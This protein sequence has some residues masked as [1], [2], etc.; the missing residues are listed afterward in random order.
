MRRIVFGI[1]GLALTVLS[2][3]VSALVLVIAFVLTV[4]AP[5]LVV[6]FDF[7]AVRK[8]FRSVIERDPAARGAVEIILCY[9]GFHAVL[10]HRFVHFLHAHMHVPVVPRAMSQIVRWFTG[11]EIHPGAALGRGVFIDHGMGVVIGETAIVGDDVTLFQGVTLGGTG[12]ETGKRHPTLE[13]GVV[14]GAGA[15]ILGNIRIGRNARVGGGSVVVSEVPPE[16]TVVGVPG[17]IVVHK[18]RKVSG[19]SLDHGNLPDPVREALQNLTN[20][21]RDTELELHKEQDFLHDIASCKRREVHASSAEAPLEEVKA[22]AASPPTERISFL[23][24]IRQEGI[25][26]IGEIKRASPSRGIIRQDFDVPGLAEALKNGG[27]RALSVLTDRCYFHGALE[28]IAAAKKASGLPVLRKDFLIDPYQ[29]WQAKAAGADAVLL[30]AR[31]LEGGDLAE[32]AAAARDAGLDALVEVHDERDIERAVD[33]G[34]TLIG[35]NSRDLTS[36]EV[37]VRRLFEL[38]KKLPEGITSVAE[39]GIEDASTV[40]RLEEAGFDAI[41]VGTY[42]MQQQDVSAAAKT[43]LSG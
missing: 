15:K 33:A 42:L 6:L 21:I 39:S 31:L 18:G 11:V 1:Y 14:V 28:Y 17:R 7:E 34:A 40:R 9:P 10:I 8:D 23:D 26:L 41:L 32:M 4:L 19:A 3:A 35:I 13:E 43:L 5:F 29:A 38:R 25:S 20:R 37:D 16:A 27:A 24:A 2:V 22:A 36:F 30:I 12:K